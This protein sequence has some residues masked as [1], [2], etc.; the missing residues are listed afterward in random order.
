MTQYRRQRLS[1]NY[2][3]IQCLLNKIPFDVKSRIL[4]STVR[5]LGATMAEAILQKRVGPVGCSTSSNTDQA[6]SFNSCSNTRARNLA[7]GS[8][9]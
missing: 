1:Y 7:E 9:T 8:C 6:K 4:H 5:Q 2:F 3:L